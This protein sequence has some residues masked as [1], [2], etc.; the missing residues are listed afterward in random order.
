MTNKHLTYGKFQLN[1]TEPNSINERDHRKVELSIGET[2]QIAGLHETFSVTLHD[3][4]E[5]SSEFLWGHATITHENGRS[6]DI[7]QRVYNAE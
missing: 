1:F 5:N 2:K 3:V 6:Y 7:S 4:Q